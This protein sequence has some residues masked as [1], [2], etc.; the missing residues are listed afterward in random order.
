ER[1]TE[2]AE[3]YEYY[4]RAGELSG[5][6]TREGLLQAISLCN[7]AIQLDPLFVEAILRKAFTMPTLFRLY[8]HDLTLLREAELLL[9]RVDELKP[10]GWEAHSQ[11]A[12]IYLAEGRVEDAER[13]HEEHI[14]K[15]D[16]S[17]FSKAG[18]GYFCFAT[19]EYSK[20]YEYYDACLKIDS[21]DPRM[22]WNAFINA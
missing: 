17:F 1:G 3:A 9:Q 11:L 4:M 13:E 8:E 14:A 5:L 16:G 21:T 22:F 2:N 10:G 20:A 18:L 6:S 7:L 15:D 19:K 12:E